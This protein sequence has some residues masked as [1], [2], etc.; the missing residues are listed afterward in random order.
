MSEA[1]LDAVTGLSG[2]GPAY[3][4]RLAE[5]LRAAGTAQGLDPATAD[6][7][8]RQT[9]LGAAT[10]LASSSEEPGQLRENV[11]SPGGTTAA[12]LA[13]LDDADFMGLI[14]RVVE[15]AAHRSREL[16]G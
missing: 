12:G 16:G 14:D 13:V 6:A 15:A 1:D 10:L 11:T 9:L 2:S 3:V 8:T 7:L 5:A 4:F